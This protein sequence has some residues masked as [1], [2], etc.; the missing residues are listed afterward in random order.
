MGGV[1]VYKGQ[2]RAESFTPKQGLPSVSVRCVA[3]DPDGLMW[4][5]TEL[6]IARYD[7][8]DFSIRHSKRWLINDDVRDIAFDSD[9]TAWIA[10]AG[11]VSA[12]KRKSMTLAE[13]AD[14]F[15]DICLAR[16]VRKPYLVEK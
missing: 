9:G 10:T 12:I 3:R 8:S 4:V 6:G 16:H 15:L 7:G 2:R 1:T 5:G 14:Y 11:G 13:K